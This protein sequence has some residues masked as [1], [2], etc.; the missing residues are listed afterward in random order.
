MTEALIVVNFKTYATAYGQA[1]ETLGRMMA[2][3]NTDARMVAVVSP[4]TFQQLLL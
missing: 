2:E 1:A 3:V 4:L